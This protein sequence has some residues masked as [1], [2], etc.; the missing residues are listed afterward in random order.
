MAWQSRAKTYESEALIGP[1]RKKNVQC[2]VNNPGQ[3]M[4]FLGL[5]FSIFKRKKLK[6]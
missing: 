1:L 6:C 3:I 4:T 2:L 5:N